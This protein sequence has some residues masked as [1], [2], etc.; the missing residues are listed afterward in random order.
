[1]NKNEFYENL[2]KDG[3][4]LLWN[5]AP[6]KK[7]LIH[8]LNST[9]LD[10]E[11]KGSGEDFSILDIG[12]GGGYFLDQLVSLLGG[13]TMYGIDISENAIKEAS[14]IYEK[15]FF[16]VDDAESLKFS[17]G[18][19]KMV[20]SYGVFEHVSNPGDAIKEMA[21][22][23]EKDGVFACMM[24]TIPYYREDKLDEGWY[25]DLNEPPQMQWNYRREQWE[26]WF[27]LAGLSL[28]PI[29]EIFKFGALK[30]GNF[31]FGKKE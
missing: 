17:N 2:F 3:S 31:Y 26:N 8:Y 4:H 7:V 19:F 29:V 27:N 28:L 18:K 14:A 15:L 12:C 11:M 21:R 24:P 13:K 20:T 25:E 9:F 6:G 30:T 5:D 1:M 10:E 16:S 22:V 23:L